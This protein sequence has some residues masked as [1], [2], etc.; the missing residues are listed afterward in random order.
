MKKK[1]Y[2]LLILFLTISCALESKF[3]LPNDEKINNELIGVWYDGKIPNEYVI[4]KQNGEMKYKLIL[5]DST[6]LISYSKKIKGFNILNVKSDYKGT[7]INTFYRFELKNDTLEFSEVNK[8]MRKV[9]FN[10]QNELIEFFNENIDKKEFF[11]N[12]VKLIRK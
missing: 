8:D 7:K 10:T 5:S 11:I 2:G 3:G 12:P 1:I 6:E 4:I 9:D